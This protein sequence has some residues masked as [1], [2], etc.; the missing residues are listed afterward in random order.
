MSTETLIAA[1]VRMLGASDDAITL[2]Q[3][4]E[5]GLAPSLV[6][7]QQLYDATLAAALR[8]EAAA[9]QSGGGG[10]VPTSAVLALLHLTEVPKGTR[11]TTWVNSVSGGVVFNNWGDAQGLGLDGDDFAFFGGTARSYSAANGPAAI[12]SASQFS[13]PG[14]FT[15]EGYTTGIVQDSYLMQ[16]STNGNDSGAMRIEVIGKQPGG[17]SPHVDVSIRVNGVSTNFETPPLV[18][19]TFNGGTGYHYALQRENGIITFRC[20]GSLVSTASVATPGTLTGYLDIWG[21]YDRV[22]N[23]V[24]S[25]FNKYV[26]ELRFS[27][28]AV[29]TGSTYTVPTQRF[30][31]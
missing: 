17:E 20:N 5:A 18:A 9:N 4:L 26:A 15:I 6:L 23:Q 28:Q 25:A 13:I 12:T 3:G 31:L 7:S 30:T 14:D 16:F 19:G 8:A 11:P 1:V 27:S 24:N 2:L 22:N 10:T 21:A 29:Y